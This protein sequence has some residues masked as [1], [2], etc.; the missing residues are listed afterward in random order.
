MR[1][2]LSLALIPFLFVLSAN[3]T[4]QPAV[5]AEAPV[6]ATRPTSIKEYDEAIHEQ[7]TAYS[8]AQGD[9]RT[10]ERMKLSLLMKQY[11]EDVHMR[12]PGLVVTGS[13]FTVL[14]GLATMLGLAA[15]AGAPGAGKGI[16]GREA[17]GYFAVMFGVPGSLAL[18]GGITMIAVGAR[19]EMKEPERVK[20]RFG[21]ST[22][23]GWSSPRYS[24]P[25]LV[26]RVGPGGLQ[27]T[28]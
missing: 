24:A 25:G 14:G 6:V 7:R 9:Q 21:S 15:L 28:F 19:D 3:A 23:P 27:G 20:Y 8:S 17:H 22:A 18:A 4:A 11:D 10:V 12:S 5:R 26:V 1:T 2:T 16:L 13:V